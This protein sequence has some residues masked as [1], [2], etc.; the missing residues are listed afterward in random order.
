MDQRDQY[1]E[2]STI[3][4]FASGSDGATIQFDAVES[5]TGGTGGSGGSGSG[6]DIGGTVSDTVQQVKETAGNVAGQAQE[7]VGRVAD[8]VRQTA[9]TR[10]EDQKYR[11]VEGISNVADT[12]REMSLNM[13]DQ[14][15]VA[16]YMDR[17]AWQLQRVSDYLQEKDLR[18]IA[19][20]VEHFA[21]RQPTMFLAGGFLLGLI[22]A[23]FIK[24]SARQLQAQGATGTHG[25]SAQPEISH[26]TTRGDYTV[27][28]RSGEGLEATGAGSDDEQTFRS[29]HVFTPRNGGNGG[30]EG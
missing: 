14:G 18:D 24:S 4:G 10:I 16:E 17:A 5:N 6:Q 15:A 21:R 23:R 19:I 22:G 20:E 28:G 11:A 12:M 2:D 1:S 8:Q 26:F 7:T 29:T 3:D 9:T 13:Q 27:E 30:A 25:R